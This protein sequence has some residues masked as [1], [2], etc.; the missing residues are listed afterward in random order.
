MSDTR[1]NKERQDALL[2]L[3]PPDT[4]KIRVVNALGQ[5]RYKTLEELEDTD[6][7][8]VKVD[9][10]PVVMT[11]DPGRKAIAPPATKPTTPLTEALKKEKTDFIRRDPVHK[12][13]KEDPDSPD[14]LNQV[15]LGLTEEAASLAFE[16]ELAERQGNETSS[17]SV[18]RVKA[19][20]AAAD[21]WLKRKDQLVG[22]VFDLDSPGFKAFMK[23]LAS[24]FRDAM[25]EMGLQEEMIDTVLSKIATS[26]NDEDWI[27]SVKNAMKNASG[28]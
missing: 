3:L 19:L 7:I 9:G 18:R 17:I 24:T 2:A 5:E 12:A 28:D 14:V 10:T 25:E 13:A 26:I 22:G 23:V 27:R 16:R 11:K 20:T 1:S 21:T 6:E 8:Q 4:K 15:V